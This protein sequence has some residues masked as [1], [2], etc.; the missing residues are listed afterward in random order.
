[1]KDLAGECRPE[2]ASLDLR[3]GEVLGLAGLVGA[4]RTELLRAIFGLD[5]VRR[6]VVRVGTFAGPASPARRLAQSVGFASEERKGEGLA[7]S[8]SIADN[9][10]LSKLGPSGASLPRRQREASDRW[11][12]ELSIKCTGADQRV[13]E[14]SGGNQQ[15]VALARLLHHDVDVLLL[16]EP[17]RGIDVASKAQIYELIDALASRGKSVLLVSSYL[18]ELFGVCDRIAVMCRGRLGAARPVSE[19]DEASV[20][21]EAVGS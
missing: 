11:I 4:G 7:T 13:L 2:R 10:T 6:G 5:P 12:R 19:W 3:R 15:K 16:D 14:L 21:R 17:T 18:P 9:L 1:V 20:M 8:L